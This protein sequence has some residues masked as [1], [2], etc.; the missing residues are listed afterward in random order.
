MKPSNLMQIL[1]DAENAKLAKSAKFAKLA[2]SAKTHDEEQ[3][4]EPAEDNLLLTPII[5]RHLYQRLPNMLKNTCSAF[6]RNE[7]SRDIFF[8]A[9]LGVIS[10]I[11]HEV[12]GEYYEDRVK[13]NLFVFIV[14][15]AANGK[16]V[17]KFARK[18]TKHIV[19]E[20][21][22]ENE[23]EKREYEQKMNE[24]RKD[25]KNQKEAE[26]PEIPVY[27]SLYLAANS[28]TSRL[29]DNLFRNKGKGI[30][31]E[32]EADS[33]GGALAQEWGSYSD[34]MRK[35]FHHETITKGR[36]SDEYDKEI[37]DPAL[38]VI[39]SGTPSQVS[40]IIQSAEDGLSSRFMFYLYKQKIVWEDP[41]PKKNKISYT[42]HIENLQ[43]QYK[44]LYRFSLDN[45]VSI[46]LEDE[47]WDSF[48]Y[49]FTNIMDKLIMAGFEEASAMAYRLGLI[50][51]RI[52][53]IFSAIRRFEEGNISDKYTANR[54]DVEIAL[55]LAE[56]LFEH[57]L[58]MYNNLPSPSKGHQFLKGNNKTS[59]LEALPNSFQRKEVIE[60]GKQ[61]NIS[62]REVDNILK[63]AVE[64]GYLIKEKA[65]L[66]IKS[67][68]TNSNIKAD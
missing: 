49:V 59:F 7:R 17:L 29:I 18:L 65:G 47:S 15:P 12:S 4:D 61:H 45:P 63:K 62:T 26:L 41:R 35:A 22:T 64:R 53:M 52:I 5:P 32:T 66:Y 19:E 67:N 55:E 10:G 40:K 31:F 33:M 56:I 46:E 2:K 54:N 28:S 68:Q 58:L 51:F 8:L 44:E 30:I 48:C 9:T 11:L 13:T 36:Q 38:S 27:K 37:D 60:L 16:G 14:A 24:Y 1:K 57:N 20:I 3:E 6:D 42:R 34:I 39:L 25:I 21:K 43:S 23:S 50:S